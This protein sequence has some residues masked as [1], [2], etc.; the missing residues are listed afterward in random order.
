MY[1]SSFD[2]VCCKYLYLRIAKETKLFECELC[3]PYQLYSTKHSKTILLNN[4]NIAND[5]SVNKPF[6]S[7]VLS[8]LALE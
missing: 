8:D 4:N 1:T 7:R 6:Y 2:E 5:A 3:S